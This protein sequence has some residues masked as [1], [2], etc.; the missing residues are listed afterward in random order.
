MV[1]CV[2]K[3]KKPYNELTLEEK[4]QLIRTAELNPTMSQAVIAEM[5]KI[6]KSNVCR[7]LQRKH[8]YVR[9]F[10]SSC[11]DGTRKRKLRTD[12]MVDGSARTTIT[13]TTVASTSANNGTY[14]WSCFLQKSFR[15]WEVSKFKQKG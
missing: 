8:E 7:I 3:R 5:Y 14:S 12:T 10:E 2:P 11:Y 6:A 4:V 13:A 1:T 15:I 9:A